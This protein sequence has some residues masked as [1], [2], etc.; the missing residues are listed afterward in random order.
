MKHTGLTKGVKSENPDLTV[1][2]TDFE[3]DQSPDQIAE[4]LFAETLGDPG[5]VGIG[6]KKDRHWTVGFDA[7]SRRA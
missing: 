2:A 4:L 3:A 6:Y 1:K 7:F 5:A